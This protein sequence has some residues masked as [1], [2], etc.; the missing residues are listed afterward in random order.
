MMKLRTWLVFAAAALVLLVGVKACADDVSGGVIFKHDS[1]VPVVATELWSDPGLAIPWLWDAV[2]FVSG[3]VGYN[4]AP[5]SEQLQVGYLFGVRWKLTERTG[6]SLNGA[7]LA[8]IGEVT[9]RGMGERV[10]FAI[11]VHLR[12]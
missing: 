11:M 6:F 10:G 2:P 5:S 7:Y 1:A 9:W 12:L 3:V 8:P 4:P